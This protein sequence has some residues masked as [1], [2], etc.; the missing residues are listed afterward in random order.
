MS[1]QVELFVTSETAGD[2]DHA[3]LREMYAIGDAFNKL[4]IVVGSSKIALIG[5][6]LQIKDPEIVPSVKSSIK[7]HKSDA[8]LDVRVVLD[9]N[10]WKCLSKHERTIYLVRKVSEILAPA[11]DR[12][13]GDEGSSLVLESIARSALR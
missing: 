5:L 8:S 3:S 13:L 12:M 10:V 6:I 9:F 1:R 7:Y 2:I 11:L 4:G